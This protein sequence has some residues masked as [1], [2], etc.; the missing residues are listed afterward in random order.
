MLGLLTSEQ[1]KDKWSL[2][3]RRRVFY[4]YPNGSAPLMGLLSL[5][6]EAEEGATDKPTFGWN[7]QRADVFEFK[8]AQASSAGPFTTT[9]PTDGSAGTNKTAAGWGE[10]KG[11]SVRVFFEDVETMQV[12]DVLHFRLVPGTSSSK[13]DFQGI[14]TAIYAVENSADVELT[15]TITNVLNTTAANDVDVIMV[16]SATAEADRSKR[17]FYTFPIVVENNTQI[18]R[19]AFDFS[20]NALQEGMTF[21]SSGPY[22]TKAKQNSLKHMTA[23]ER[24]AFYS[25]KTISTD[26]VTDDS[27]SSVR[28]T[29]GGVMYYLKQWEK[30]NVAAG[31]A[32]DYR[33]SGSDVSA[34]AW[35]SSEHKRILDI[36]GT[37]SKDEFEDIIERTFRHT[38]DESFEKL[39]ICGGGFLK[40]F[41][42][43]V[44]RER[45]PESSLYTKE[46]YGM[47]VTTW[48]SPFGTLRFK[49]HPL[50]SHTPVYRNSAFILDLG[51]IKYTPFAKSDTNLLKHRQPRDFDGRKDEWLTEFGLE[52]RYP[53]NHVFIDRLTGITS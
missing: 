6:D 41:N 19:H 44:D 39:V 29:M 32:F 50:M 51:E 46:E 23:M 28:R 21:D 37:L 4:Q 15:E 9:T 40:A 22:K 31:G 18:F 12:R 1:I 49:T 45:V 38:N 20:R 16:G 33:P 8:T 7:E 52:V 2:N 36:N 13:K 14:V 30:G 42:R 24:A 25:D 47:D 43:F 5:V 35:D 34:G 11:T 26:V 53:E 3:A 10:T 17:G 27:L 48:H